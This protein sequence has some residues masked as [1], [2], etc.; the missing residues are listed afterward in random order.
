MEYW[1]ARL[2]FIV[3]VN[4]GRLRK[5]HTYDDSV[6]VFRARDFCHA[7]DRA[8]ELGHSQETEYRNVY[9]QKVRWALVKVVKLQCVGPR[10]DGREISS[11]LE[12]RRSKEPIPYNRRF[13]P[14][15]LKPV[16]N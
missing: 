7:F 10:L 13:H 4:D 9:G 8:L 2:T 16:P 12:V 1:S 11:L 15:R 6:V 5:R 14:E 3:L